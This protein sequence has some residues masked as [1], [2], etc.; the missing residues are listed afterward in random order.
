MRFLANENFPLPSILLIR[1]AGHEVLSVS[2]S[3]SGIS[4]MEVIE[5]AKADR[6]IILT[7]DKDYGEIIF[8]HGHENPPAVIFFRYKGDSPES[9]GQLLIDLMKSGKLKLED[10]FT[11][12]ENESIRQRA[13]FL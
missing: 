2:E 3:L 4:D 6:S 12:I 11:V 10:K 9:A 7:F 8:K 13:Y 5:K 1:Q